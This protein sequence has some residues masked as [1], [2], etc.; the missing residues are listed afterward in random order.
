MFIAEESLKS[1]IYSYGQI[2]LNKFTT[3]GRLNMDLV[4][5]KFIAYFTDIYSDSDEKFLE[6]QGRKLFLL[7]LKPIINGVGYF[8]MEA[9]TRDARR[10]DVIVDYLG[11]QFVIE[12]KIW[13]GNEYNERGEQQLT[14][15]LDYF[16]LQ[17]GYM[18]SFNFNKKKEPGLKEVRLGGKTLIEAVV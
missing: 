15:Y 10:T 2:N 4:L 11:E 3:G 18:L 5:E 6:A 17:K 14:D 1:E 8:Y 7:Y 16:H 9:Q 12:L 13:R